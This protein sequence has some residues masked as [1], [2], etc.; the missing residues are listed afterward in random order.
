[1]TVTGPIVELVMTVTGAIAELVV[2]TVTG[3]IVEVVTGPI[4]VVTGAIEVLGILKVTELTPKSS[5]WKMSITIS[6]CC[7]A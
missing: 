5:C 4:E 2:T 1:M 3:A 7:I 6:S